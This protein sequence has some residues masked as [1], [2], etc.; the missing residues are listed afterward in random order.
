MIIGN[1]DWEGFSN[2]PNLGWTFLM[3]EKERGGERDWET[4]SSLKLKGDCC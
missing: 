1:L 3:K 4:D 2:I